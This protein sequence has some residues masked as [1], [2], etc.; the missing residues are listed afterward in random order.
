MEEFLLRVSWSAAP[1]HQVRRGEVMADVGLPCPE[2]PPSRE[3]M[4]QVTYAAKVALLKCLR[5]RAR[6]SK[7]RRQQNRPP[8]S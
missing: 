7:V 6:G 1:D 8:Q 4:Q 2:P 3:E 5:K